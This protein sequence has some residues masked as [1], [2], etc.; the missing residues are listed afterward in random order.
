MRIDNS[1]VSCTF[2]GISGSDIT[3]NQSSVS[4]PSA[5][6]FKQGGYFKVG[7]SQIAGGHNGVAG[8]DNIVNCYDGSY[9]SIQNL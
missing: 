5:G 6:I 4:G 7:N 2:Y 3:I 9:L 8:I 1:V